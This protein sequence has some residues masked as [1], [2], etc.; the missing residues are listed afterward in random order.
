MAWYSGF[1]LVFN[2]LKVQTFSFLAPHLM[3][4][5]FIQETDRKETNLWTWSHQKGVMFKSLLAVNINFINNIF[6]FKINSPEPFWYKFV[7]CQQSFFSFTI[8]FFSFYLFWVNL[9]LNFTDN[10]CGCQ[11]R[12]HI[13]YLMCIYSSSYFREVYFGPTN[14][15]VLAFYCTGSKILWGTRD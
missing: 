13:P 6:S 4:F 11:S 2:H 12:N 3:D 14:Y 15:S 5:N 10:L 9:C 7:I 1:D 8:F